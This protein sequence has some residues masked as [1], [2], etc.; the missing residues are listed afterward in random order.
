MTKALLSVT[1]LQIGFV[2]DGVTTPAVR[3]LSLD[4]QPGETVALVGESG[5][6]KSVSALAGIG[7]LGEN[8]RC[9]G[10]ICWKGVD[11]SD[12]GEDAM[13]DIRGNDIGMVFQEP[14]TSLNPLHTIEKQIGES[15][16]LHQSLDRGAVFE[17]TIA[18]LERVGIPD[19]ATR[20]KAYP[21]ELSGGQRQRVMIAMALANNP[22]L[23]I[24]DEPTTALD[25]TI[26]AQILDLLADLQRETGMAMLFITHDLGVVR[27]IADRVLVMQDGR[28]VE[29]GPTEQ[30]FSAPSEAY[31][32]ALIA[33]R[34]KDIRTPMKTTGAPLLTASDIKVHFPIR[35]GL[36]RRTADWVR[37]VDGVDLALHQGET[38]GIV[39]ESGSGKSTLARAITHLV[40]FQG[41]VTF[42]STHV[43]ATSAGALKP[44]R[45][46][47]QI[48]FQDPFGSLSPRLSVGDIIGEGPEAHQMYDIQTRQQRVAAVLEEVGLDPASA[49]RYPH[50]FSGGQRQRI[51]IARALIMQPRVILFD[52]PT[53]ALDM[54]VQQQ[55]V[56]LLRELQERHALSYIFISHDIALIGSM[57]HRIMVMKDGKVVEDGSAVQILNTPREPYT[58]ELISAAQRK[59]GQKTG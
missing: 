31:T 52:E 57:S 24:A 12:A 56:T 2:R 9:S 55:L 41:K 11:I 42:D 18:L 45:R 6:G 17:R 49:E 7:L 14:M 50:E 53:S 32:S 30:V 54:T 5:S 4:I 19:P 34:P 3:G 33:A 46:Q 26:E 8:A 44:Y 48:V 10:R 13:R 37:A 22:D 39:G 35:R 20:I 28:L 1:D 58:G 25:V 15:L 36:L 51:A 29:A 27:Q 40:G 59:S 16:S 21:H 43:K 23:L 38:L 47:V